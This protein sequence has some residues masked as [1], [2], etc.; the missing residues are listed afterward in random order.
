MSIDLAFIRS[1]LFHIIMIKI[2]VSIGILFTRMDWF[3]YFSFVRWWYIFHF[4]NRKKR[5]VHNKLKSKIE[6][7]ERMKELVCLGLPSQISNLTH[8]QTLNLTNNHLEVYH[9]DYWDDFWFVCFSGITP[10]DYFAV[11]FTDSQIGS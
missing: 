5:I 1:I 9:G 4:Q 7:Y 11:S 3:R 8:L 2:D 10:F 6:N